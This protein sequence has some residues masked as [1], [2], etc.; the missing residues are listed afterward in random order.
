MFLPFC[1][2]MAGESKVSA[3]E[4]EFVQVTKDGALRKVALC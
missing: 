2:V 1:A 3:A 4:S